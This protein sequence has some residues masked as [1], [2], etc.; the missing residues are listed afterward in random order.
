MDNEA[1]PYSL[2]TTATMAT[3]T[4]LTFRTAHLIPVEIG[5]SPDGNAVPSMAGQAAAETS[6]P[7]ITVTRVSDDARP[8][9]TG[10]TAYEAAIVRWLNEHP[11]QN[12][13][14]DI[15]AGCGETLGETYVPLLDGA[16]VHVAERCW[17]SYVARRREDAIRALRLVC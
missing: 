1:S 16:W 15:C 8:R 13:N 3:N 10:S 2:A 7:E 17:R 5:N 9:E 12:I 6:P 11:P 14:P 4:H